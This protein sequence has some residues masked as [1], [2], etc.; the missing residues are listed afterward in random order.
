MSASAVIT[1]W[2]ANRKA[3]VRLSAI[4]LPKEADWTGFGVVIFDDTSVEETMVDCNCRGY[5]KRSRY[6]PPSSG[7]L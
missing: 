2:T 4:A 7:V 6:F 1:L 3:C 5:I